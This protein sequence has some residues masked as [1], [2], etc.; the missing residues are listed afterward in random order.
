MLRPALCALTW[1][2]SSSVNHRLTGHRTRA[3]SVT[4]ASDHTSLAKRKSFARTE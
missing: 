4:W 1:M 2:H 3:G